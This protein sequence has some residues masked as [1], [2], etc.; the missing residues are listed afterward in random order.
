GAGEIGGVQAVFWDITEEQQRQEQI[1][2]EN[3]YLNALQG[4]SVGLMQRLDVNALLQDIVARSGELVGTE[5]GYVF[6]KEPGAGEMELRVGVGAYEG[7]VG[8]RTK[9]GVGLAGE[10]WQNNAPVV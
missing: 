6:I 3:G 5:H 10:V 8:R 1:R 4:M 7:F 2:Q 9:S